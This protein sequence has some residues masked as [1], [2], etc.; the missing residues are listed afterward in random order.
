[1]SGAPV[2]RFA[3]HMADTTRVSFAD[4]KAPL[5]DERDYDEKEGE[6]N[7]RGSS[8]VEDRDQFPRGSSEILIDH[9]VFGLPKNFSTHS[10]AYSDQTGDSGI[11]GQHVFTSFKDS[12]DWKQDGEV[13]LGKYAL[14]MKPRRMTS[15][16]EKEHGGKMPP[17]PPR[18]DYA[19]RKSFKTRVGYAIALLK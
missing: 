8:L 12:C 13:E 7:V 16:F 5:L 11:P 18:S 10:L 9:G 15:A 4:Q 17:P 6:V 2:Y 3:H 19:V 1:M 14:P